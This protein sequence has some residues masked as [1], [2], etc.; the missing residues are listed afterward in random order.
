MC[1][2]RCSRPVGV[3]LH[4]KSEGHDDYGLLVSEKA[5][6][7]AI[8]KE[9]DKPVDLND[10]T[11]ILQFEVRLQNGLECAQEPED[12]RVR[13]TPPQISTFGPFGPVDPRVHRDREAEQR[14][15][16][17]GRRAREKQG[18]LH[19]GRR[20]PAVADPAKMIPDPEDRKPEDWDERAKIPDPDATKPDDWDENAPMEILDEEATMPEGWLENEPE[21]ID[22]P[23]ALKPEDW[24]EEEDGEWEVP[25]IDN[26]KCESAPGCGEW[27]RPMKR[28]PEYKGKWHAPQIDNPNY[29]GIWRPRDIPNPDYFELDKPDLSQL[30][31]DSTWK[32]KFTVE[33]EKQKAE[34]KAAGFEGLK[35]IQKAVFDGLYKI[36]ELPFFGAHKTK[37]LELVEKAEEQPKITVSIVVSVI[38]IFFSILLRMLFGG[39]KAVKTKAKVKV[40]VTE[41]DEGESKMSKEDANAPRCKAEIC[42]YLNP[43]YLLLIISLSEFLLQAIQLQAG[44]NFGN[45]SYG[46]LSE[47]NYKIVIMVCKNVEIC[48]AKNAEWVA[49]K[50]VTLCNL[51]VV[52]KQALY[53]T[54]NA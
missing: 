45:G 23:E 50:I 5:R 44:T 40:E 8:V 28:N 10:G 38:V 30:L 4:S 7:Y 41:K 20:F 36:A 42:L 43:D 6:K 27:R 29:M 16:D 12:R 35:G 22:D 1:T 47:Q 51:D 18:E 26:P 25:K 34:E 49:K 11:T 2:L 37:L 15:A 21:E 31:R 17:P 24:D 9:L 39:N 52:I 48:R 32:P 3:W 46:L 14:A 19:V 33:E 13:R 54:K 53:D